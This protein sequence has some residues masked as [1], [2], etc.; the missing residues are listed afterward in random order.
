MCVTSAM[1]GLGATVD[2]VLAAIQ[3]GNWDSNYA[4]KV[5]SL[6]LVSGTNLNVNFVG[7]PLDSW[8]MKNFSQNDYKKLVSDVFANKIAVSNAI[9]KAPAT[10]VKV[11]YYQNIK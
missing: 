3:E 4:G 10:S 11:N 5:S 6:G 2:A 1:K 7:L 9:D 8:T